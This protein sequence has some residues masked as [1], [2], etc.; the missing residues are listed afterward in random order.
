MEAANARGSSSSIQFSNNL[1]DVSSGPN[2][3]RTSIVEPD[4]P[5]D[6]GERSRAPSFDSKKAPATSGGAG[7]DEVP[8]GV[9]KTISR[10]RSQ[11]KQ[12]GDA[13][14]VED[15]AETQSSR[16]ADSKMSLPVLEINGQRHRSMSEPP[17]S[18][19]TTDSESETRPVWPGH[20]GMFPEI[21]ISDPPNEPAT[22]SERIP[23]ERA[24]TASSDHPS[25]SLRQPTRRSATLAAPER[26]RSASRSSTTR[27]LRE[28]FTSSRRATSPDQSSI[29]SSESK[30]SEKSSKSG[31]SGKG[32][33]KS[34]RRSTLVA[35]K[36]P[37]PV[38]KPPPVPNPPPTIT[39]AT[40]GKGVLFEGTPKTPPSISTN[41]VAT[42]PTHADGQSDNPQ[43][44]IV[45]SPVSVNSFPSLPPNA[46]ISPS[47]NM[48]S[49]R[50]VRSASAANLPSKPSDSAP[51]PSTP[52][53]EET[54]APGAKGSTGN[55]SGGGFF[56]TMFSAAQNA[57]STLS[58]SFNPQSRFRSL[59]EPSEADKKGKPEGLT[60]SVLGSPLDQQPADKKELAIDTL[61]NGNLD[62][63]HL[64]IDASAGG[65]I[66]TKDGVVF[67]KM[68]DT[69][70]GSVS[71]RDE[72]A[73]R[74]EDIRAARAVS[75]AYEKSPDTSAIAAEGTRSEPRPGAPL[76]ALGKENTGERT[77]PVGR[78][79][80][81]D[82]GDSFKHTGSLRSRRRNRHRGSS[83]AT[84]T[85]IGAI[86]AAV[87]GLAMPSAPTTVPRLTG[88]AVASKKRNRDF[89][90]LFRSV[91]E[92][93][94]LIEDYSC[95]LQREIILAGRIY[96]SE[97]H[98]CFS[99]NIL[100][101]VTTLVIG[102]DEVIAI[103]K[104]ST[105][106][107][108][109]NAIAVQTLH[110][111][112][113]F[114]SLLSRDSTY[115]L[116]VNIWKQT[117]PALKSSVNGTRVE[118]GT[119]DKTEKAE[120]SEAESDGSVSEDDDEVYDED[121]EGDGADAQDGSVA[122]SEQ[123][124]S[125]RPV[126]RKPS[127]LPLPAMGTPQ[128][129]LATPNG[130]L[131]TR[132]KAAGSPGADADFPGPK[133]HAPTEFTDPS[134]CYEKMIK[135]ETI[136]APLG[137]VYSLVFGPASGVFMS[138]FLVESQKVTDLQFEDDKRGLTNETKTRT[139]SYT[140]PLN[141]SIG[142]KQTK[143]ISTENLDFLDL[144]KAVL[145][146]L[147]TQTPDVPYGNSF[148]VKTKYLFTWAPGN[149][150][151]FCMSCAVEYTGRV[152]LKGPIE[153]GANDGQMS[154]GSDLIKALKQGIRPRVRQPKTLKGKG[155][156]QRTTPAG[157]EVPAVANAATKSTRQQSVS[158]GILEPLHRVLRPATDMFQPLFNNNIIVGVMFMLLVML[159]FRRPSQTSLGPHEAS[160]P[161]RYLGYEE[162]WRRE[163]SELWDWLD[164][165]VGIDSLSFSE[166]SSRGDDL[167]T[168]RNQL[169]RR[170]RSERELDARLRDEKMTVR[171]I[172]D[173]IRVT[174]ERL[175]TLQR[176]IERRKQSDQAADDDTA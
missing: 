98:I 13:S 80:D 73:A 79:L 176:V 39:P 109:P 117:H 156:R 21:M 107:V 23:S 142:P 60:E 159:W 169:R 125:T 5:I 94:Y 127:A 114:R 91:P 108:F 167:R 119:G 93:D 50:R 111:R 16:S 163:E 101:W 173:A 132:D 123:P 27:R 14:A 66:K 160:R 147:T 170:S 17:R 57:A 85:T 48:I 51:A 40:P 29:K 168:R 144:E 133:T 97:G 112:H 32:L 37:P 31:K 145:V 26:K 100:G 22:Q 96:I 1:K 42:S 122:S 118:Q 104:E 53:I 83:G 136:P 70:K 62:F 95:A 99:S 84:A 24:S 115:D 63:S 174:Y 15:P 19:S 150:T 154:Y 126:S 138:K 33:F 11:K 106:M 38:E 41:A 129:G 143:C 130:D 69:R 52:T 54:A 102:F 155:K 105:A 141:G 124:D 75:M 3:S 135:D 72:L 65:V 165:R 2:R 148:S 152:L 81:G 71:R 77:P 25:D 137:Q 35:K 64:G 151:R 88:F 89:H 46:V 87:G 86:G 12:E 55:Q 171:E 36:T 158:W 68:D 10:R 58:S 175:E 92:D 34:S 20:D 110:A 78:I 74:I 116:M 9:S 157:A 128:A 172:E 162:L 164:E 18:S 47:G 121:E 139:Y 28:V 8:S 76:S 4:D 146:T 30:K 140:K 49:H 7:R 59:T 166:S 90:Q 6:S 161:A 56:S 61:G 149:A 120:E 43:I 131:K 45:E 44:P 103:E 82:T 134:G 153:K 67:T 113:T